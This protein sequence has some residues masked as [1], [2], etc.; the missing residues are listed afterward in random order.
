MR[1]IRFPLS[2]LVAALAA[3]LAGCGDDAKQGAAV[4]TSDW[5]YYGGDEGG[6][7]HSPL[8]QITPAN[9]GQ[10]EVAWTY[11]PAT[12]STAPRRTPRRRPRPTPRRASRTRP[13]W[14]I[15][16]STSARRSIA[17]SPSIRRRASRNGSSIRR[18]ISRP[19]PAEL[20]RRDGLDRRPGGGGRLLPEAD[21]HGHRRRPPDRPRCGD[22]RLCPDFGRNGVVDLREGVGDPKPGEYG[23]TSPPVVLRDRLITGSMVLDNRRVDAPSGVVR[24]Y[25]ARTGERLWAWNALP[26]GEQTSQAGPFRQGTSNAWSAFSTDSARDLVFVP[27]GNSSPDYYGG[28]RAGLDYYSSSVVALDGESGK[29]SGISR[30]STTT[31]GTTTSAPS[32]SPSIFRRRTACGRAC[33]RR[34]RWGISSSSIA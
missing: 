30:P 3:L 5:P 29:P 1:S 2:L 14:S 8:A 10:L 6:Q 13:S 21:L 17:S 12:C 7:R 23:V 31:S 20:P 27:T 15:E 18:S 22:G 11:H 33:S 24:A 4:G 26:A 32:P 28:H 25:S 16:R 19:L 9:V 34:R